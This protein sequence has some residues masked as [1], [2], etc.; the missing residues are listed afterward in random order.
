MIY[1]EILSDQFECT[2]RG[3]IEAKN[4]GFIDMYFLEKEKIHEPI[5]EWSGTTLDQEN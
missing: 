5:D 1:G 3:K 4:K 2:Y